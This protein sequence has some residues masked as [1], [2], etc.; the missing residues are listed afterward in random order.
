VIQPG[1][2]LTAIPGPGLPL[3]EIVREPE[4]LLIGVRSD[5]TATVQVM[6]SSTVCMPP[7]GFVTQLGRI[8]PPPR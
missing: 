6:I 4:D 2:R 1:G 3:L 5:T 8:V 7:S